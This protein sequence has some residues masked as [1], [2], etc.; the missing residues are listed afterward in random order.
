MRRSI[1]QVC[2]LVLSLNFIYIGC[3]KTPVDPVSVSN[4][5]VSDF[6]HSYDAAF[7]GPSPQQFFFTLSSSGEKALNYKITNNS[8]WLQLFNSEQIGEGITPDSILMILRVVSPVTLEYGIYYDTIKIVSDSTASSIEIEI[9]L[10]IGSEIKVTP[11]TFDFFA[12]VNGSNPV[13]QLLDISSSTSLP[14]DVTLS[15]GESWLAISPTSMNTN[16]TSHI[17]IA[18][19][20]SGL[21]KGVYTD[22]IWITADSA[23]NS[24]FPVIVK[25]HLDA[26]LSQTSP[27]PNNLNDIYFSDTQNGWAVG[28]IIDQFTKSGF[29][30]K[31]TDGGENWEEVLFLS[32][33]SGVADSILGGVTFVGSE[34]WVVGTDGIILYSNNYGNDWSSQAPPVGMKIDFNDVFFINADSGW[35]VGDSGVVLATSDGGTSWNEQSTPVAQILTGISFVDNLHGWVS[36]L[37]DVILVTTNGGQ[38]WERQTVQTHP[39]VGNKFDF[40]EIVFT[41]LLHGW[42]VGKFGLVVSTVD[43]GTTWTPFQI[44]TAPNLLSLSF[45]DASNG[46]LSTADGR[47]MRTTNGGASWVNQFI[48]TNNPFNSIYFIDQNNGWVAGA[49][50]TIY[51]TASGGE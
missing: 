46:W 30:L 1:I 20:S 29:M 17:Q 33:P 36:G 35:I 16:D 26:W 22:T 19:N 15:N 42:T 9:V 32:D 45:V 24:P 44:D 25:F 51:N 48:E 41:D 38:T 50:G 2:F 28:D 14:F 6:S 39:A 11:E 23:L 5:V 49:F 10:S 8:D 37:T 18:V 34:G 12:N 47:V 21:S 13:A 43:G 3:S 7:G 4:L 40:K 27:R 31:T